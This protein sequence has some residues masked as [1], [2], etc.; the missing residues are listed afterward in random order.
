MAATALRISA[1]GRI[2]FRKWCSPVGLRRAATLVTQ[3]WPPA[4]SARAPTT[5][6]TSRRARSAA[7]SIKTSPVTAFRPTIRAWVVSRLTSIKAR[8]RVVRLSHQRRRRLT[9]VTASAISDRVPISFRKSCKR[10][11]RKRAATL[12][13]RLSLLAASTAP[14]TISTISRRARSPARST[15]TLLAIASRPM[16]RAWAA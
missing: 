4:A 16:T 14:A 9:A 11:G 15:R 8:L 1:L 12:G 3:S 13:T 2:S 5:S 6:T 7:R 10:A